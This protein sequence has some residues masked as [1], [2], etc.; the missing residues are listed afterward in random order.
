MNHYF[1]QNMQ[2]TSCYFGLAC[3]LDVNKNV[4][5]EHDVQ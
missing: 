3:L 1:M 2:S 5:A 4:L